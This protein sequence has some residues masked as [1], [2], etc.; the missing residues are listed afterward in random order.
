MIG[1]VLGTGD[2]TMHKVRF[3]PSSLHHF[4]MYLC[5]CVCRWR[6]PEKQTWCGDTLRDEL[7][8]QVFPSLGMSRADLMLPSQGVYTQVKMM[9]K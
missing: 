4:L 5:A 1:S 8:Y 3:V 9:D 7:S 2:G 6:G